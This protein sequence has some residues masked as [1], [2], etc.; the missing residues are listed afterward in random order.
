LFKEY[1]IPA[2]CLT[3]LL[4]PEALKRKIEE[5]IEKDR[6]AETIR[7]ITHA[8]ALCKEQARGMWQKVFAAMGG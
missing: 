5:M 2:S 4:E 8:G 6:R 3:P 1:D 7:K